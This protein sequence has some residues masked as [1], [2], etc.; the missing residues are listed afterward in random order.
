M[1]PALGRAEIWCLVPSRRLAS[2]YPDRSGRAAWCRPGTRA[3]RARNPAYPSGSS[4]PFQKLPHWKSRTWS[5]NPRSTSEPCPAWAGHWKCGWTSD[6]LV[7][8]G[9]RAVVVLG[10]APLV[11]AA[12]LEGRLIAAGARCVAHGGH[13]CALVGVLVP[14][15]GAALALRFDFLWVL[16]HVLAHEFRDIG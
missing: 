13:R 11:A 14:P 2:Q 7:V 5:R 12:R 3:P 4:A 1:P 6:R 9:N 16:C 15:D 8:Y 10:E